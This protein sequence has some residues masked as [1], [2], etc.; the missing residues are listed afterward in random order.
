MANSFSS[1]IKQRQLEA[2]RKRPGGQFAKFMFPIIRNMAQHDLIGA[3]LPVQP[4]AL[5]AGQM[6][7]MDIVDGRR[8][9]YTREED[10]VDAATIQE[11]AMKILAG[12][13]ARVVDRRPAVNEN[14]QREPE[15]EMPDR[16][17]RQ[18]FGLTIEAPPPRPKIATA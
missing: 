5:P 14:Q 9:R 12:V 17:T 8:R 6:F 11:A 1:K 4:M 15:I 2:L 13:L 3:L 16:P 10:A 7:Y 18:V